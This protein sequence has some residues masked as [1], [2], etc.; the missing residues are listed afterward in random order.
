MAFIGHLDLLPIHRTLHQYNR[1]LFKADVLA[2]LNVALLAFPQG[3]AYALIAG[4][5]LHYGIFG[6]AIAAI[7][8]PIFSKSSFVVMGPTNTPSVILMSTFAA[9]G[10]S[11]AEQLPLLSLLLLMIG[12]LLVIG[13]YLQIA[14]LTQYI[15]RSVLMGYI[16]A[17][18]TLIIANQIQN[19]LGFNFPENASTFLEVCRFT[20]AH[21]GESQWPSVLLAGLTLILYLLLRKRCPKWPNVAITLA[22]M[23]LIAYGMQ[24]AH[25]PFQNNAFL[26]PFD[27]TTFKIGLPSVEFTA[28]GQLAN[29][30]L[31]IAL[32]CL[33]EGISIGKSLAERCGKRIN[34][35]QEMLALGIANISC[36]LLSGMPASGSMTRSTL[37]MNSGAATPLASVYNGTICLIGALALGGMIACIP[38]AALAVLVIVIGLSLINYNIIRIVVRSTRSD[39]IVFF[40]TL[41]CG[42]LFPLDSAIYFGVMLSMALFLSKARMPE[43]VEY[44]FNVEGQLTELA[45]DAKRE[46]PQISIVHVEGTLFFGASELFSDRVRRLCEEPNLKVVILKMRNAHHL[47]ATS[48]MALE[49]LIRYMK[50][51]KRLLLVSEARE[52]AIEIF[53][54]S[55]LKDTLGEEHIFP[56][57][58]SNPTASTANALKYAKKQLGPANAQIRIYTRENS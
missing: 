52:D 12:V 56:E 35:N 45:K 21:I 23:A 50:E 47:D 53:S 39:A 44:Q 31:A 10:L 20:L 16:T 27:A 57:I 46:N 28:M 4:L 13:A 54:R 22:L 51:Q 49:G 15:S 42:L 26:E 9:M 36:G 5:P 11:Q 7:V 55:G 38:R 19:L 40:S 17:A 37:N 33:L 58:P 32:L 29:T 6:S 30:A 41:V 43:M 25:V 2:G 8:G 14:N 3:M 18:A 34:A 48:V 1:T 24:R